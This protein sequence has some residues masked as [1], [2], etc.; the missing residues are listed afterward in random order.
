M[1]KTLKRPRRVNKTMADTIHNHTGIVVA[2]GSGKQPSII[3]TIDI[4]H[5]CAALQELH[6]CI[7][8]FFP[9]PRQFY[10]HNYIGE[11]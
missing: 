6:V 11:P 4:D 2:I 9:W 7:S 8:H 5:C 1:T 3:L 10:Y